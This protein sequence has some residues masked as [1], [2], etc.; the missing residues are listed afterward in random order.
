MHCSASLHITAQH[1]TVQR[2]DVDHRMVQHSSVQHRAAQNIRLQQVALWHSK[3]EKNNA[4]NYSTLQYHSAVHGI[5]ISI[6]HFPG[7]LGSVSWLEDGHRVGTLHCNVY[8]ALDW[9]ALYCTSL[10]C[11]GVH[12]IA[13]HKAWKLGVGLGIS[14]QSCWVTSIQ[15][16]RGVILSRIT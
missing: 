5:T 10:L 16:E 14:W 13:L 8:I 7:S 9:T 1:I 11:A 3:E 2:S 12:C 6:F 15:N 4:V